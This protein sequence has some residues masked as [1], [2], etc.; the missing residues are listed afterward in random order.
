VS[1]G[2]PGRA[3]AC[4]L[5]GTPEDGAERLRQRQAELEAILARL[6]SGFPQNEYVRLV[7]DDL[8]MSPVRGEDPPASAEQLRDEVV[9][10]LPKLR[11]A[12]EC[13]RRA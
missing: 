4:R 10:R 5:T 9:M 8:I 1:S 3:E 2:Q 12:R 11:R 13:A 6:D 7:G